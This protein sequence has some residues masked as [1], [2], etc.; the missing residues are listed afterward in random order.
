M[1]GPIN[2]K[3]WNCISRDGASPLVQIYS[4]NDMATY[5]QI[6]AY[7]MFPTTQERHPEGWI[8][9]QQNDSSVHTLQDI[10][11]WFRGRPEIE[12]IICQICML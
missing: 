7:M 1:S 2:V 8:I 6:L 9:F 11:N 3:C 12:Q 10:Q 5:K 4:R